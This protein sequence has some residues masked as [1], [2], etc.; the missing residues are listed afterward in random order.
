MA[1]GRGSGGG[2]GAWRPGRQMEGVTEAGAV[3]VELLHR[4]LPMNMMACNT[5]HHTAAATRAG[6]LLDG[7]AAAAVVVARAEMNSCVPLSPSACAQSGRAFTGC[8]WGILP[9]APNS[10]CLD[11]NVHQGAPSQQTRLHSTRFPRAARRTLTMHTSCFCSHSTPRRPLVMLLLPQ[12][13]SATPPAT[14]ARCC[15]IATANRPIAR[16]F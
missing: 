7:G 6:R 13:P 2:P 1:D 16:L 8:V 12:T 4:W 14:A 11:C 10:P 3:C 15:A 9:P 5:A